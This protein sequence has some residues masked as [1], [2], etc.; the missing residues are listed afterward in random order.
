MGEDRAA[1]FPARRRRVLYVTVAAAVVLAAAVTGIS[2]AA[3]SGGGTANA[4]PVR[5]SAAPLGLNVA[6]WDYIYAANTPA[7][8]GANVIQPMLETAG[9]DQFRYG[10]GSYADYYDWRTNTDIGKCLPGNATASFTARCASANPLAFRRAIGDAA[11]VG[12]RGGTADRGHRDH[13]SRLG[14]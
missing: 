14:R 9:V 3:T 6:P 4:A 11:D 2:L 7:G 1:D 5:L 10:G 12:L 13:A 8:G